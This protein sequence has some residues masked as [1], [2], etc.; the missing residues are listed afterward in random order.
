M[1]AGCSARQ[2]VDGCELNFTDSG[3]ELQKGT[4]KFAQLRPLLDD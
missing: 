1:L 3:D 2:I 4:T